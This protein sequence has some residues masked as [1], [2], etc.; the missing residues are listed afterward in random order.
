MTRLMDL[1]GQTFGRLTVLGRARDHVT[2]RGHRQPF[3]RV[4]CQCGART[5]TAG[6][7]LRNGQVRSCGCLSL[8]VARLP[9]KST[10][11]YRAA[12]ARIASSLGKATD[13]ACVR[14]SQ[15]AAE[16]AY[17]HDDPDEITALHRVWGKART[18]R[19]SVNPS[20]YQPMC[21]SCH[22][23]FDHE[24]RAAS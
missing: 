21:R 23:R 15:P 17:A 13:H 5:E 3:W 20:H 10:V 8:E 19:Y 14:C 18:V 24:S 1:S 16:W 12:H 22:I 7:R 4:V 2:P 11:G 6:V 9:L